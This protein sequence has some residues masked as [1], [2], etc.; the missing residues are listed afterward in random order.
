[1]MQSWNEWSA[2]VLFRSKI[3]ITGKPNRTMTIPL[4]SSVLL[5]Y[6]YNLYTDITDLRPHHGHFEFPRMPF[7]LQNASIERIFE[8]MR[9]IDFR[10]N[11]ISRCKYFTANI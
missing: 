4:E 3:A 9:E 6:Y 2:Q 7:G 10:E 8:Y 11:K 1:M 5:I